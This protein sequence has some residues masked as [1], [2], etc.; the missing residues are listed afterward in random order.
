MRRGI[1][2]R[3]LIMYCD[4]CSEVIMYQPIDA[5]I[6]VPTRGE[7]EVFKDFWVNCFTK[8]SERVA[9]DASAKGDIIDVFFKPKSYL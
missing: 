1:I 9:I 8:K 6:I 2:Q 5:I 3:L 4:V 7:N